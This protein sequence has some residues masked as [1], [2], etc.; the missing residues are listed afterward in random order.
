[1][2]HMETLAAQ[3]YSPSLDLIMLV[4][5]VLVDL[6]LAVA[7]YR[8]NPTSATNRIFSPAPMSALFFLL[9]YT[10]PA[11]RVQLGRRMYLAIIVATLGMM[12]TNLS[13]YAFVSISII[14]GVSQPQPGLGLLP[15]S[16]LSTLFSL[17]TIY[18]L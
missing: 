5:A 14:N 9:A 17:L 13:P 3:L 2:S 12:A 18:W 15:F 1:M 6:F 8:S 7:V 16:I 11:E 10:M 4:V